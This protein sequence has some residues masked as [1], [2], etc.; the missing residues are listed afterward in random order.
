MAHTIAI[1]AE[2]FAILGCAYGNHRAV[3]ACLDD[4]GGMPALSCGDAIGFCGRSDIACESLREAF[5]GAIAG[6]HERQAAA[7]SVQCGCGHSD[8]EDERLSCLAAAAQLDG[9]SAHDQAMLAA[10]PE[11][12]VVRGI[13]GALLLAHGSPDRINEFLF[14]QT[15]DRDRV[16]RWLDDSGASVLVVSHSGLPWVVE[17][18]DGRLAVNCGSAGKPD[19]DGDPAVHYA[20]ITLLPRPA[21][22][23]R[24][25]AYDHRAAAK[26]LLAA[27]IEPRFA[28][29]LT[30]GVWSWGVAAL[31]EAERDRPQRGPSFA[32]CEA[33]A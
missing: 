17:L 33:R 5:V 3:R 16:R 14:A 31:P 27:G 9:L 29:V 26:E 11:T 12:L 23:I 32:L 21:A 13:G 2:A 24:R 25:V 1:D 28:N 8:A 19:H 30:T 18:G 10:L 20:Q 7:G 6:N 15:I 22:E 4:A